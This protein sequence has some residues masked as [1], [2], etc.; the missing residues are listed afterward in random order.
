L[1]IELDDLSE[2]GFPDDF[3]KR[4]MEDFDA[5]RRTVLARN[6]ALV[7]ERG[8]SFEELASDKSVVIDPDIM[9]N[10]G[11]KGCRFAHDRA[12]LGE[13][14]GTLVL[15][16]GKQWHYYNISELPEYKF[17]NGNE[18]DYAD[19]CEF[20]KRALNDGST[21]C[22]GQFKCLIKELNENGYDGR[23][24]MVVNEKNEIIDGKHRACW[25]Y[26]KYG[27]N[28]KIDIIRMCAEGSLKEFSRPNARLESIAAAAARLSARLKE[29]IA[30][31][32][33]MKDDIR[34]HPRWLVRVLTWF[35]PSR[36]NR[37]N[38]M[39]KYA[40]RKIK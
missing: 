9:K 6:F 19:Y 28:C 11:L 12:R 1:R 8:I 30:E 16:D 40:R 3:K 21:H 37:H 35:V 24:R 31:V 25:L 36:R 2:F 17:L 26:K 15:K 22:P 34:R 39:D 32:A 38:L 29:A 18:K 33:E 4:E 27:P 20:K 10:E 14:F 13:L 7:E 5:A 23:H